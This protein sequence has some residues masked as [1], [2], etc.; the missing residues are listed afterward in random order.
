MRTIVE[1]NM[2]F[3]P[4][5]A[6][7]FFHI[8][9]SQS[10]RMIENGVKIAEFLLLRGDIE[11][12]P[13]MWIV[14][15]KSSS[16]RPQSEVRFDEF[17]TEIKEKMVNAFSLG[18]ASSMGRHPEAKDELPEAFR[19]MAFSKADV[20][21]ILVIKGHHEA[22]LQ[23]LKDAIE[24]ALRT[25]VKTWSLS[26]RCVAV[27]NDEMACEYGLILPIEDAITEGG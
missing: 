25:T 23:P 16:P 22:W 1:S 20:K 9:K 27:I 5:S 17:I 26:P 2:S 11:S 12:K 14:E 3:G 18:W 15:A 13:V 7:M 8:E 4:F 19:T 24:T 6:E 10:Y 21:F